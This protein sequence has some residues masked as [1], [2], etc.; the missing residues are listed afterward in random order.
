V[1]VIPVLLGRG[2][3]GLVNRFIITSTC[4]A[5]FRAGS[6][7]P[8]R[9][10]TLPDPLSNVVALAGIAAGPGTPIWVT[11]TGAGAIVEISQR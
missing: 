8:S 11:E 7:T 1:P 10:I 3:R 6:S 9:T 5:P 2:V 4:R